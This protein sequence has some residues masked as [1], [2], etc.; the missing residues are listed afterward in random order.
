MEAQ[1]NKTASEASF[2]VGTATVLMMAIGIMAGGIYVTKWR[3]G[4]I[5][6]RACCCFFSGTYTNELTTIKDLAY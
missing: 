4:T 2:F 6:I 3:P 1:F 5:T